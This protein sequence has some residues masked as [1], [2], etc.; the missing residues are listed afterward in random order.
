M[1]SMPPATATS[2]SP[3]R[4]AWSTIP[5]DRNPD[6]QTLLTVSEGTSLGMRPL[7]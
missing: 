2:M 6:A 5:A 3:L 1:D 4:T 7:I